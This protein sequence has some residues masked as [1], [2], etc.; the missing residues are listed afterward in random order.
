M[1]TEKEFF[2][3]AIGWFILFRPVLQRPGGGRRHHRLQRRKRFGK[4]T[5]LSSMEEYQ[6]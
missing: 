2:A 5:S 4:V 6:P 1:T 3:L